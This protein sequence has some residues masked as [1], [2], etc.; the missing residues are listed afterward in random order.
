MDIGVKYQI[1]DKFVLNQLL[2]LRQ[3]YAV[4]ETK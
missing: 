2:A 1:H 3:K 4:Y